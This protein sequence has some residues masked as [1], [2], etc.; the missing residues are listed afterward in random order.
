MLS[1]LTLCFRCGH[2]A[3]DD[4]DASRIYDETMLLIDNEYSDLADDISVMRINPVDQT[5]NALLTKAR[6]AVQ[7]STR[8]GFEVKVSEALHKG[9]PVIATKA[10]GIPLQ[11]KHGK[12]GYIV[13][14]GDIYAVAKHLND[15]LY[16]TKLYEQISGYAARSISDEVGTVGN[17]LCW[18]YLA[19]VMSKE[20]KIL[21]NKRWINDM[22][23]DYAEEPYTAKENR[24][25]RRIQN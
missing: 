2:G 25:P 10:G 21:P 7:L 15:L 12:N 6:I 8:E 23:R 4:P 24:L 17:A 11:I 5:L 22:A 19:T 9:I 18:L 1:G 3:I 20:E 14:A 13:E 16:N